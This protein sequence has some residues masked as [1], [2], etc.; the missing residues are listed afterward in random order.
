MPVRAPPILVITI[1]LLV[2][3]NLP[4]T[5]TIEKIVWLPIQIFVHVILNNVKT[6][7]FVNRYYSL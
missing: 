6:H 1:A 5:F 3:L 7:T 2:K 4:V